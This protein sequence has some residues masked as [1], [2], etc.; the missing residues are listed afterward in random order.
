MID[1]DYSLFIQIGLFLLLWVFL[2]RFVFHPFLRMLEQREQRTDGTLNDAQNLAEEAEQLKASYEQ[3]IAKSTEEGNAIKESIRREAA[4]TRE[5]LLDQ[6]RQDTAHFLR[7][8]RTEIQVE[9]EKGRATAVIEAE[10][11]AQ[12]MAEKILARKIS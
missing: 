4:Q 7:T 3:A 6:A 10:A 8:A 1:L 12:Q 11:I 2:S 9:L 5:Q